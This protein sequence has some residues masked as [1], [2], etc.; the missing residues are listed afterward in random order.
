MRDPESFEHATL[1]TLHHA[2]LRAVNH[3]AEI[4]VKGKNYW[5]ILH[6]AQ[7]LLEAMCKVGDAAFEWREYEERLDEVEE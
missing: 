1:E 5:E 2:F 7:S 3:M 4:G 6:A